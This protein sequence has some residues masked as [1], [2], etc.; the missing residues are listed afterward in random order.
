MDREGYYPIFRLNSAEQV[1][2]DFYYRREGYRRPTG[3]LNYDSFWSSSMAPEY[4]ND[5]HYVFDD[6][7]GIIHLNY[8]PPFSLNNHGNAVRCVVERR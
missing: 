7:T 2:I 5:L 3:P 6:V 1:V 8:K 4:N